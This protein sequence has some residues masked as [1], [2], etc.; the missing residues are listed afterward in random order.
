MLVYVIGLILV[1]AVLVGYEYRLRRPDCL[2]L[3]ETRTGLGI[4]KGAF[5]P[6]HF[7][8][9]IMRTTQ[10]LQLMIDAAA[11]GNLEV[12]VK[13]VGTA[14]PSLEHLSALVRV[15]GW[16]TDAVAKA[17]G[18]LQVMLQGLVKEFTERHEI[19]TLSSQGILAY[20]N[21]RAVISKEKLGLEVISLAIQSFEPADPQI[22]EALRQ[23]EHARIMEQTEK[24]T[25]QARIATAKVK[26]QADEEIAVLENDLELKKAELKRA[27]LEKESLLAQQRLEGELQRSRMRLRFEKEELEML[28][29]SP[30]L[31]MLTPQA[32]RLAE[33]SQGLK[34]A[35]TIVSLSSQDLPQG[36]ELLGMFHNLLQRALGSYREKEE[37]GVTE[38][39]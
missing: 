39:P 20:L 16:Q 29:S 32:A 31:L 2:V 22:A 13:L 25:H 10:P 35:R 6:R 8:L 18:E 33:A 7:S 30:E 19:H 5:Y 38:Q 28:K 26:V 17:A 24:L 36:S 21:E 9:P 27:Q 12:R 37:K 15:G 23:Q 3:Y 4:R 11:A 1:V 34:N 14:A